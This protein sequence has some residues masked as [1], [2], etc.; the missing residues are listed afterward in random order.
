MKRGFGDPAKIAQLRLH[1]L[2]KMVNQTA[3]NS[4]TLLLGYAYLLK[5][6]NIFPM[7]FN[8]DSVLNMF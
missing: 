8:V 5:N 6:E 7:H 4:I 3:W 2:Q 1:L